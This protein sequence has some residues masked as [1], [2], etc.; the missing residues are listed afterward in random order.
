M[1]QG[2]TDRAAIAARLHVRFQVV[3]AALAAMKN[4]L[5]TRARI[6]RLFGA[7]APDR[8]DGFP[9]SAGD[10][11]ERP[12]GPQ[13]PRCARAGAPGGAEAADAASNAGTPL[14]V[15]SQTAPARLDDRA[16]GLFV[17][18]PA[19]RPVSPTP[20]SGPLCPTGAR[21]ATRRQVAE[22]AAR[23]G[24][25]KCPPAYAAAVE[26][27]KPLGELPHAETHAERHSRLYRARAARRNGK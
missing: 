5:A 6:A 2:I 27:A 20:P 3:D 13:G 18:I 21:A 14:D 16:G 1:D 12:L 7:L 10:G 9:A 11:A 22:F 25:T 26:G 4:D 17:P 8:E 19:V 23:H 24:V 15:S